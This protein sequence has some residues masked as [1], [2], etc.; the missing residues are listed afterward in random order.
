MGSGAHEYALRKWSPI[1]SMAS[2]GDLDGLCVGEAVVDA[3][4][5][6]TSHLDTFRGEV[7]GEGVHLVAEGV[8][9]A[10]SG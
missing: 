1:N 4:E 5:L 2:P 8:L 6:T 7:V 3:R 10:L 9:V